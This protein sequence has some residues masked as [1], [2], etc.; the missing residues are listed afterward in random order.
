MLRNIRR[1]GTSNKLAYKSITVERREKL[2]LITLNRPE[3]Y[4]AVNEDMYFELADGLNEL[5]NDDGI[6]AAAITG[7]GKFY[8]SGNDLTIFSS[9]VAMADPPAF[10]KKA[11]D[12]MVHFVDG[13]IEFDKPLIAMVNGP[14]VGIAVSTLG[15]CDLESEPEP[16]DN[17]SIQSNSSQVKKM[18]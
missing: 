4:N 13:F 11:G 15:L 6:T 9:P 16:T 12:M 1:L 14:A 8:S 5:K 3:I 2:G 10:L 18:L 17:S 7:A